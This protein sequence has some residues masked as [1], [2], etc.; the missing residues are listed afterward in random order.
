MKTIITQRLTL[1]EFRALDAPFIFELLN[2]PTWI[3]FIGSRNI[4]TL[5][6]AEDYIV[7]KLMPSYTEHDFGF[8]VVKLT[9]NETSIGLCGLIKRPGLECED[10]GFAFLPAF[11]GK[12][13]AFEAASATLLHAKENL[14][15]NKISAITTQENVHSIRL[16]EKLGLVFQKKIYLPADKEELMLFEKDLY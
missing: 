8:Y 13:Y 9:E 2:T 12:G 14:K 4:K 5:A 6:D 10:I 1:N 16:L 7:N 15:L 3:Q 11:T